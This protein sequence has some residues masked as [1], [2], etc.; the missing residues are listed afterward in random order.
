[1]IEGVFGGVGTRDRE[2]AGR[3]VWKSFGST[4]IRELNVIEEGA[5]YTP[6]RFQRTL[7]RP[8]SNV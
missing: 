7:Y 5:M 4:L 3:L 8:Y 1:M 2:G 6:R